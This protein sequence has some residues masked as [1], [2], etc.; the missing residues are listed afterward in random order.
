MAQYLFTVEMSCSG[1]SGAVERALGKLQGVDKI[2]V[3]LEDQ[4]VKVDSSLPLDDVL[5]AI[6]K[7]GKNVTSSK[8]I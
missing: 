8:E 2:D 3:S 6:R 5:A 4:T 1:C 7:T